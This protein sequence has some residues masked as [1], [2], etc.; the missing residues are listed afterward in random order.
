MALGQTVQEILILEKI[1]KVR[2]RPKFGPGP[3]G[4][5]AMYQKSVKE[6]LDTHPKITC[7]KFDGSRSNG[8]GGDRL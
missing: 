7:M 6:N 2:K 1:H 3:R 5:G 8:L 4:P